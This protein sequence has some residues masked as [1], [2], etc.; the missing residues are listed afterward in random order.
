VRGKMFNYNE[1]FNNLNIFKNDVLLKEFIDYSI[2]D[3]KALYNALFKA[4][5]IYIEKYCVDITTI[6]ST[7][8][9]SLKIFRSKYLEV[10]IPI[11]KRNE[12]NFIR[13]S[14]YGGAT[15]YYKAF[16]KIIFNYDVNSLYPFAMCKPMPYKII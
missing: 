6:F 4:P 13:K 11:L 14:Y 3:S 7:S 16:G 12:D 5:E 15:D 9:L 1:K 10:G 2:L 8:T